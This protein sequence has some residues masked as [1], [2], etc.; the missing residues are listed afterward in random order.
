[1][2]RVPHNISK[3]HHMECSFQDY[4]W[5]NHIYTN[6]WDDIRDHPKNGK[7]LNATWWNRHCSQVPKALSSSPWGGGSSSPCA[8]LAEFQYTAWILL[9]IF[10]SDIPM[11][12]WVQLNILCQPTTDKLWEFVNQFV[13]KE[14]MVISNN[15]SKN[16]S[17]SIS[18]TYPNSRV[19][20][21]R[22]R[23]SNMRWAWLGR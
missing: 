12:Q 8:G 23:P 15:T 6:V 13:S 11:R 21:N 9:T 18:P 17:E 3:W 2:W 20:E 10:W 5:M 14:Q 1:M 19:V 22:K 7:G 4:D 16:P